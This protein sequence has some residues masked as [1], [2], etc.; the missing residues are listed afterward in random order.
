MKDVEAVRHFTQLIWKNTE[1][2]GL[3]MAKHE[4]GKV[5]FVCVYYPPGNVAG[6]FAKNVSPPVQVHS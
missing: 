1:L 3:G 4:S 5:Y 2:I 6:E